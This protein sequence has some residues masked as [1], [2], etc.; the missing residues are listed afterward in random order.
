MER[1]ILPDS[2]LKENVLERGALR[3]CLLHDRLTIAVFRRGTVADHRAAHAEGD[4]QLPRLPHQHHRIRFVGR[5]CDD[6]DPA[7]SG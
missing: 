6:V 4:A 5:N 2:G 1:Q 7:D 3:G